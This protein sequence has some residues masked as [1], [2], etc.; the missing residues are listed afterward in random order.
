MLKLKVSYLILHALGRYRCHKGVLSTDADNEIFGNGSHDAQRALPA[1]RY[2]PVTSDE[3]FK[4]VGKKRYGS[5]PYPSAQKRQAV[6][7]YKQRKADYGQ[8]S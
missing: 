1:V 6:W 5:L 3:E 7:D 4:T 8:I 2:S